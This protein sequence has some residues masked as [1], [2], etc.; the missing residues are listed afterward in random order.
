[1]RGRCRR[2]GSIPASAGEPLAGNCSVLVRRVYPRECGGTAKRPSQALFWP[3]LSPRVRGNPFRDD[4]GAP[5]HGS[6]P[7]SAGEPDTGHAVHRRTRVYP[8]E[9]GGTADVEE[10][11]GG[12]AGLS[13]RVRGNHAVGVARREIRGSIPA[14]AGE[15]RR[16]K[17]DRRRSRVYPRECGGTHR[18]IALQR[19][20]EGLSPRVRGN[21]AEQRPLRLAGGSIPASAGEPGSIPWCPWSARVYPRECGGTALPFDPTISA[22]GLSP[23]VRGNRRAAKGEV[24]AL[25]SIPA[26]AGE[27]ASGRQ[28]ETPQGVYPR[29]CGGTVAKGLPKRLALGLSPRVRGNP[30]RRDSGMVAAGSIPA[31][32]GEPRPRW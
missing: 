29:E 14:S 26:S 23:R 32:A 16:G 5:L 25:G 18:Q 28:S 31:S 4:L 6:I 24:A 20:G 7:A 19:L 30:A 11:P 15:P 3:G 10:R 13:P 17:L 8:R 22:R 1:M 21:P 12:A 9:C 2:G 27:P